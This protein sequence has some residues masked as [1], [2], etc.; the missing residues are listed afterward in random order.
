MKKTATYVLMLL[1]MLT[2]LASCTGD[3][4]QPPVVL[5]EGG[6]GNGDWDKP[7][8]AYQAHLG[9]TIEGRTN[10]WVTGYIVGWIDVNISNV[11]KAETA[12]FTVPAGVNTNIL[13]AAT[14]DE[15]N[16][17]KCVPVQLPSGG[18][19]DALNLAS[20]PDNLGRQVTL[21]GQTG[22]KYCSAYGVRSVVDFNWGAEGK[23][24]EPIEPVKPEA[25]LYCDFEKGDMAYYTE[26]GWGNI[27][28]QGGLSGWYTR[29]FQGNTYATV[30]ATGGN[31]F[32]GPYVEWLVTP[33][34]NMDAMAVK[35]L[36][37]RTQGAYGHDGCSLKVYVL[38]SDNP[39]KAKA[40]ELTEA[41]ICTPQPDGASPVYS[42]WKDSGRVDISAFSG[43]V[44]IGFCYTAENGGKGFCST[45]C[46]DDIN[47]GDAPTK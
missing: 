15:D 16:W 39:A 27:S 12:K 24:E 41:Q 8:T 17:E 43:T 1:A 21:K 19:R 47:I 38:D 31:Q 34:V 26:R 45:Y 6:I 4:A 32:G 36:T 9:S 10:V 18:V 30:S 11:L 23:Y 44:Y 5:P 37:F 7:M 28:T 35:T 33:P 46:V 42:D 25:Q 2:G 20:H 40:T 29:D 22:S 13:I 3:Y 14:P